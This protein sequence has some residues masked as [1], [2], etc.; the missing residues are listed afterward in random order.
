MSF[1]NDP[2]TSGAGD[3]TATGDAQHIGPSFG[4]PPQTPGE[5]LRLDEVAAAKR[6]WDL[7]RSQEPVVARL[8]AQWQANA[9][10]RA[11][12][13]DVR[14]VQGQD[15]ATF[16][17]RLPLDTQGFPRSPDVMPHMNKA[18]ALCR[19][20]TGVITADPPAGEAVPADGG[21]SDEDAAE[22]ATRA[23]A[24]MDEQ[25]HEVDGLTDALDRCH[26]SASAFRRYWFRPEGGK[27]EPVRIKAGHDPSTG[28]EAS[29]VDEAEFRIRQVPPDPMAVQHAQMFGDLPP[30]PQTVREPWPAFRER[31]VTPDGRLTDQRREAATRSP[32]EIEAENLTGQNVRLIPHTCRNVEDAIGLQMLVFKP[33]GEVRTA[34]P[35]LADVSPEERD[36]ILSFRP[37]WAEGVYPPGQKKRYEDMARSGNVDERPCLLLCTYYTGLKSVDYR[38]GLYMVQAG[39]SALVHRST[40]SYTDEDGVEMPMML[41]FSQV[42]LFTEGRPHPYGV[43]LM[44]LV[45]PGGEVRAAMLAAALDALDRISS[46]KTFVDARGDLQEAELMDRT[47]RYVATNFGGQMPVTEQVQGLPQEAEF[48]LTLLTTE[49]N[50]ASC[51]GETGQGLENGNVNSG[52]QALAVV[53]QVQ[54]ALSPQARAVVDF[55]LRGCRIR[56]ELARAHFTVERQIRWSTEDG[57]YKQRAWSRTDMGSSTDV[58]LKAGTMSMLRPAAKALLAQQYYQLGILPPDDFRDATERNIGGTLALQDDPFRLRIR[59]QINDWKEGPP[60]EWQPPQPVTQMVP[61][62]VQGPTGPVMVQTPQQ[63]TPPDPALVALWEPVPSDVLPQVAQ[64]RLHELAKLTATTAYSKQPP[65]W[66][67]GVDQEMARMQQAVQASMQPAAPQA[68][69]EPQQQPSSAGAPH[70]TAQQ[71]AATAHNRLPVGD[72]SPVSA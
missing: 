28:E 65:P 17:A 47:R 36:K 9:Y 52:V 49:M 16:I 61:Q 67:Q 62:Q 50:D 59:R 70:Q 43:G 66:R 6:A 34:F 68:D 58:R 42:K 60:E 15:S 56:L 10:R 29:H 35:R 31:M 40:L 63:V 1:Q 26:D 5:L 20:M 54:A 51:L 2:S 14:V 46:A 22:F 23:L 33:W 71:A 55:Y 30:E 27:R 12:Y 45:G 57:R 41:P 53:S 32:G 69:P 24:D 72:A 38:D 4:D 44:E 64:V 7:W 25:G 39:E 3:T 19:K 8:L 11:G 13:S 21:D 37:K 18:A 48:I